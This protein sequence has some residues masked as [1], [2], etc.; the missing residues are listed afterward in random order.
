M[1]I[2]IQSE[3]FPPSVNSLFANVSGRGRVRTKRYRE[4]AAASGWDCQG[5]G[6]ITGPFTA[7]IILSRKHRRSNADLDNR[8][9]P[10]LDLLQAH[11]VIEDDKYLEKLTVEWGDCKG[12]YIEITPYP[13]TESERN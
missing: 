12:F 1:T 2:T 4:W 7:A 11:K 5:K 6:S 13:I 8:V 3:H 9:K 10:L